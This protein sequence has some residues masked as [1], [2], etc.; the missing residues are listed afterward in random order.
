MQPC[1]RITHGIVIRIAN[2][3]AAEQ[4]FLIES[5][6][7]GVI[8]KPRTANPELKPHSRLIRSETLAKEQ[9]HGR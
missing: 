1:A 5:K 9:P 7:E 2:T 4:T 6:L 3:S 8:S